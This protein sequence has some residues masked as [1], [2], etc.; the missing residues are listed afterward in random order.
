MKKGRPGTLLSVL[1]DE[2]RIEA[3]IAEIFAETTTLGVRVSGVERRKL[4]RT[5][6]TVKTPWGDA[7]VKIVNRNGT[8]T[9]APEFE[10][11]R[12]IARE[13]GIPIRRV[14]DEINRIGSGG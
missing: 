12:R 1:A 14:Y 6:G 10:E 5:A 13:Q 7:A 8:E 3:C 11:C 2:L 4:E 9:A